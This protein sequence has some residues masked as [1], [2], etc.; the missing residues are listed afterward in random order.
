MAKKIIKNVKLVA[1]GGKANPAPPL[2]P[3]LGQAGVNIADFC[4]KFNAVSQEYMGEKVG[5][6]LTVYDDRT[7]DF[8]VK[9]PI[10]STMIFKAAGI[11]KG[12]GKNAT[13][14][15]GKISKDK[16]KEIAQNKM[17]DLNAKDLAGAIKTIEGQIRSSGITIEG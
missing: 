4:A 10:S 7:Y 5:V 13:S 17:K 6:K 1:I 8:V 12:S 2:G 9:T 3:I 11:E 14:K 16:I 15:V